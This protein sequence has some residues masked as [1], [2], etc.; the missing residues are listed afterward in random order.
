M[1]DTILAGLALA[2]S[3]TWVI[4]M[5]LP[6]ILLERFGWAGFFVF[7]V[8]NVLGCAAF[9]RVVH[10][11]GEI[12]ERISNSA[13]WFSSATIAFHLFFS[14]FLT[15]TLWPEDYGVLPDSYVFLSPLLLLGA[16]YP[17]SLLNLRR[18]ILVGA[19]IWCF[20][21]SC[22]FCLWG[23]SV[24]VRPASPS[25]ESFYL[26]P[27]MAGGFLICPYL[28]LTFY[29]VRK[30][31]SQRAFDVFGIAFSAM[32]ALTVLIWMTPPPHLWWLPL[33]HLGLQS[34]FTIAFHI[35][36]LRRERQRRNDSNLFPAQAVFLP[37]LVSLLA[38][39][40]LTGGRSSDELWYLRFLFL[41]GVAFP[42]IF[43][44]SRKFQ[45]GPLILSVV[46]IMA[47]TAYP[48]ELCFARN[49]PAWALMPGGAVLLLFA[50]F[51]D[52]PENI[53]RD[54]ER[55]GAHR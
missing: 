8:S 42:S 55:Q 15:K 54:P 31:Y 6:R 41:Y 51:R 12:N 2:S 13:S 45:G 44:V 40:G 10:D 9:G 16:A 4:G 19:L 53:G 21:L 29:E 33:L 39:Y 49:E 25:V 11:E 22:L 5:Y 1:R 26:L 43:L 50:F 27:L 7:A 17:L 18:L 52:R 3:W 14:V 38:W 47:A 32:L 34:V 24:D 30:A 37:C 20:S 23:N 36:A 35:G 28:D 46:L 48:A